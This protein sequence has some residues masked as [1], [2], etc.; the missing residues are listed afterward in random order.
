MKDNVST[1]D[2]SHPER[3]V[4]ISDNEKVLPRTDILNDAKGSVTFSTVTDEIS[5]GRRLNNVK[6]SRKVHQ[7]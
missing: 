3:V 6:A 5:E 1:L 7:K 4:I 2:V